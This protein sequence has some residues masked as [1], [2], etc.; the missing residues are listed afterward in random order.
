ML[1]GDEM[2]MFWQD[3]AGSGFSVDDPLLQPIHASLESLPPALLVIAECDILAEQN[4]A[5]ASKLQAAGVPTQARVY[6][7]ASH[8]FL[9]AVSIAAIS[10][11]AFEDAAHWLRTVF[12]AQPAKVPQCHP[13]L[14]DK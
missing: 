5:M 14:A 4:V 12:S 13:V 8:S 2:R 7:G 10:D 11:L 3:Y 1:G 6:R 9:E